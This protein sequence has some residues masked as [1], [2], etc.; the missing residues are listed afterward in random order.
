MTPLTTAETLI[1]QAAIHQDDLDFD[2]AEALLAQAIAALRGPGVAPRR[3]AAGLAILAGL[4][5]Q[6][7]R[8]AEARPLWQEALAL[9]AADPGPPDAALAAA[10]SALVAEF[11]AD[12]EAGGG[13]RAPDLP[14]RDPATALALARAAAANAR[15]AGPWQE[16]QA[17][18]IVARCLHDLGRTAEA[19]PLAHR[20]LDALQRHLPPDH[21]DVATARLDLAVILRDTD[22]APRAAPLALA[23]LGTIRARFGDGSW[24]AN[25]IAALVIDVVRATAPDHPALPGLG[26][27]FG[28]D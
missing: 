26:R 4:L 10:L 15:A 12:R 28:P 9:D 14:P 1:D 11:Q 23:A 8:R 20:A 25:G 17:T 18:V 13:R 6:T 2:Q 5:I 24:Y 7:D 22:Q 21:L 27:V 16:A 3:L 19:A